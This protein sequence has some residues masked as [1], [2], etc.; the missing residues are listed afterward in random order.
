MHLIPNVNNENFSKCPV[1]VKEK[2]SK[3]PFKSV[4]ARKAKLLEL[5][6]SDLADFKNIMSKD[7]KKW[8]ITFVDYCSRYTKFYLLKSKDEA[9]RNVLNLQR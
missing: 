6:H 1:C 4:T 2:F 3:K 5:M 9:E 7:G 8:Y